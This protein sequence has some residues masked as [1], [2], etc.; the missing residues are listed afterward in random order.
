[1]AETSVAEIPAGWYPDPLGLPQRRWWDST[2]WTQ[3][4]APAQE[5]APQF[6][7]QRGSAQPA[8]QRRNGEYAPVTPISRGVATVTAIR[9]AE[10]DARPVVAAPAA[11]SDAP[12][13]PATTSPHAYIP[14]AVNTPVQF[15]QPQGP[16]SSSSLAV[17]LIA[18]MPV[19]Q[20]A[21]VLALVFVLADFG[22]FMQV[23]VGFIFFLWS[24]VLASR[25]KHHLL[26][27]G[28][29]KAATPW[30]LLLTPLAYLIARTVC[31]RKQ[32]GHGSAPMWV[33]ILLS[34]IPVIFV[35]SVFIAADVMSLVL[36][37][38]R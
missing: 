12:A 14:M 11:T 13:V 4:V 21:T 36:S 37:A 5:P 35:V 29:R 16:R 33:Y 31:I 23:A 3:H 25:D 27:S 24:A 2:G 10:A 15:R 1:M 17:W 38:A 9:P 30:W 7:E 28:H 26:L 34:T 22:T 6:S 8:A 19:I 32:G 18:S 20:F